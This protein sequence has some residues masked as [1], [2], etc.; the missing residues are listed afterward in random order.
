MMGM[1][2]AQA[3]LTGAF[4]LAFLAVVLGLGELFAD[5]AYSPR[6]LDWVSL[7][8]MD[9]GILVEDAREAASRSAGGSTE[10]SAFSQAV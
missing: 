9:R 5:L 2:V 7:V 1:A 8:R 6:C 3:L 4:L 10:C